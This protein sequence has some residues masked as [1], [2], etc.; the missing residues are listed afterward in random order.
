MYRAR[1]DSCVSG[2]QTAGVIQKKI[3]VLLFD[4]RSKNNETDEPAPSEPSGDG[5]NLPQ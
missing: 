5:R 2:V 1:W 4:Y 3:L